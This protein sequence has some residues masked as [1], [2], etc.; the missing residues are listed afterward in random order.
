M[1]D[2]MTEKNRLA[3]ASLGRILPKG[4]SGSGSRSPT[5]AAGQVSA[6]S[7]IRRAI[8][9]LLQYPEF[10]RNIDPAETDFLTGLDKPGAELLHRL[11][12]L[13]RQHPAMTL[14][15][16]LEHFRGTEHETPLA[17]LGGAVVPG[18]AAELERLFRDALHKLR[19]EAVAA[20]IERLMN[21]DRF[22]GLSD[23]EKS[24]LKRLLAEKQVPR[25]A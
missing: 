6:M 18:E 20:A 3:G 21:K 19:V 11:V 17:T 13:I 4:S 8:Q 9:L 25:P 10:A 24:E 22:S 7:P 15:A 14:G 5:G 2:R 1:L 16:L 12:D 23:A